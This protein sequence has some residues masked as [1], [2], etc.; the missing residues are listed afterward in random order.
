MTLGGAGNSAKVSV[1]AI[2]LPSSEYSNII[3]KSENESVA[4]VI[5]NGTSATITAVSEGESVI[6]VTHPDS[7]NTIK[8]YV[9][10]GSEYVIPEVEPVVY[11]SSQ[12]VLTMLRDD[13]SQKLQATL[14][15]YSETVFLLI[16]I[17]SHRFMPSQK[18]ELHT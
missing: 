16:M 4:T 1:T 17:Q 3:W 10:V 2:S 15:N 13:P 14:V 9:R 12:D 7:Q 6:K 18:A 5:S 8:I 11:I